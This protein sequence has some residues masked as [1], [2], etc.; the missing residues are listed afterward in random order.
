MPIKRLGASVLLLLLTAC[1]GSQ[2]GQDS[3]EHRPDW[4]FTDYTSNS[5]LFVE[6]PALVEGK[7]SRF[8]AH[9]TRLEDHQ[10]VS[11]GQVEVLL[12]Q[13]GRTVAGFRIKEPTR[14]GL[15]TPV[16]TPKKAGLFQLTVVLRTDGNEAVHDLGEIR[17]YGNGAPIDAKQPAVEGEVSYLKEQQWGSAFDTEV[18]RLQ[19]IRPSVPVFA[20]VT[21]PSDGGADI[22]APG[23]GYFSS[24]DLVKAGQLVEAGRILGYLIPNSASG[25]DIGESRVAYERARGELRLARSDVERLEPLLQ[26]GAIPQRRLEEARQALRL[27]RSEYQAARS[28]LKQSQTG[29]EAS[30]LALR[31]PLEGEVVEVQARPGAYVREGERVFRLATPARR[32]L[33]LRVPEHYAMNLKAASGVWFDHPA[34]G[35]QVLDQAVGGRIVQVSSAID[36]KSRT[37]SVTVEYPTDA[38]PALIGNRFPAHLFTGALEQR[39]AIPRSALVDDSGRQVVFVQTGGETFARREVETG[40]VDGEWV[41]VLSGVKAGERVVSEGAWSL[42]LAAS[43]GDEIGHGHAH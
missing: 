18:A 16:V 19:P 28:R 43:G 25:K 9:F 37:A 29:A 12:R 41:E 31:A 32:W 7:A 21:V 38:G 4:V 13:Q 3:A 26:K 5:E 20:T 1:S 36:P 27:A 15:F 24:R 22:P 42:R 33:H 39:L 6:F 10:P 2:S 35:T 11:E 14:D 34:T 23:D 40:I 17:V 30:G 8:L